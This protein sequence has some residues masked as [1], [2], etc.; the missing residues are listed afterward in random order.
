MMLIICPSP[1]QISEL[2]N[3][4]S[5][6]RCNMAS[7]FPSFCGKSCFK[8]C[9]A[10]YHIF[11]MNYFMGQ[12]VIGCC[13]KYYRTSFWMELIFMNCKVVYNK[14]LTFNTWQNLS[15]KQSEHIKL[16]FDV[17]QKLFGFFFTLLLLKGNSGTKTIL[18]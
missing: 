10:K 8:W 7:P 16:I 6:L 15:S 18:Y 4:S 11:H 14:F 17:Y 1:S 3:W 9:F 2:P 13:F 12:T 5:T